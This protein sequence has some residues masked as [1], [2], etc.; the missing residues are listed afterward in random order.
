MAA[1]HCAMDGHELRFDLRVVASW[2][3]PGSRVLDLGCAD[4]KL[5]RFLR[6]TRQV[7]GLGIE[8]DE[9]EVVSC[10]S[11]GLSVIHGDIN[12]ELPGFPDKAFDYVVVSQTLQQAYEPT[13]LLQQM[14][15]V[16]RRGI[17]SF[18]N[19]CCLPIRLQ[20]AFSGHVP[21]T[22]ELPYQWYNTPNIRVLS[23][24]DFRAYS[25][26][27][28][29]SIIRALAVNPSGD[30]SMREVRFWPN[31]LASYGIFMIRDR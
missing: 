15:R 30:G 17:V 10:I 6:D 13:A 19:F 11:Q 28:P 4:G 31:L 7:S 25:R 20:M 23:L 2:I 21:V 5:L 18:P 14:L 1:E 16:G 27:V 3:E 8:H 24:E 9:D 26:A 29:F 12:T 22:P